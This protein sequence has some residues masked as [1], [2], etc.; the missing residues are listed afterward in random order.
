M[1]KWPLLVFANPKSGGNRGL[2]LVKYFKRLLNP[3][4]VFDITDGGPEKGC[5]LV[6]VLDLFSS[7]SLFL[8]AVL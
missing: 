2:T 8:L 7:S 6:I 5:V 1:P 4:Q 3:V